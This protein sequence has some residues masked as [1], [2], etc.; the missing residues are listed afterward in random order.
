MA[1]PLPRLDE[2]ALSDRVLEALAVAIHEDQFDGGRLPSEPEI[3]DQMGVSRTTVRNALRSLEQ[4]GV[5]DRRPGRGTRLRRHVGADV[6]ALHGLVPFARSLALNHEVDSQSRLAPEAAPP[7]DY[8]ERLLLEEAAEV[9]I[10]ERIL[11]TDGVPV[12][13]LRETLPLQSLTDGALAGPLRDSILELNRAGA[14]RRGIDHAVAQ[15]VPTLADE[16]LAETLVVDKGAPI[17]LLREVFYD[18]EAVP[19][20]LS[21]VWINPDRFIITVVRSA[22]S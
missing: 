15:V 3:A 21:D 16:E 5:I 7:T 1:N 19:V 17:T 18:E 8:V 4:I 9:S 22:S 13:L 11:A 20:A 12:M 14:F 6:L 2:Q 10:I